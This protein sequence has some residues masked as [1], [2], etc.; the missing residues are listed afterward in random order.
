MAVGRLGID[1]AQADHQAAPES[2]CP[3]ANARRMRRALT[4]SRLLKN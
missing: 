3:S 1:V 4:P 2:V